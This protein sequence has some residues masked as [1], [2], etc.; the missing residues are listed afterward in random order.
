MQ[1]CSFCDSD[2]GVTLEQDAS[3]TPFYCCGSCWAHVLHGGIM[4]SDITPVIKHMRHINRLTR[5]EE[6]PLSQ[7][8]YRDFLEDTVDDAEYN[9]YLEHVNTPRAEDY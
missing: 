1:K 8:A 9:A 2:L 3:G 6:S 7:E 5:Q 4:P